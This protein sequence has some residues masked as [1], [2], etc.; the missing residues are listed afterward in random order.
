MVFAKV[1]PDSIPSVP[2][3]FE[4][5][6]FMFGVEHGVVAREEDGPWTVIGKPVEP[7][8][9]SDAS[10]PIDPTCPSC[11]SPLVFAKLPADAIPKTDFEVLSYRLCPREALIVGETKEGWKV[12]GRVV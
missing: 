8:E 5:T 9:A 4:A 6:E 11:E 2:K 3:G 7:K 1:R 10:E 12:L